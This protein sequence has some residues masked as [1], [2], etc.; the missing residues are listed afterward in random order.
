[1]SLLPPSYMSLLPPP[2]CPFSPLLH[3]PSPPSYMTCP[4]SP[5]LH[6]PSPPSYMSLLPPPTCPFSPLL[7]VPSPPSYMS[8]LFLLHVPPP[9]PTCP[10]PPPP[11]CPSSP[12]YMSLLTLLHVPPPPSYMSLL[13]LLLHTNHWHE[14]LSMPTGMN[15]TIT[16][17]S[18][19]TPD[20]QP[21]PSLSFPSLPPPPPLL[22]YISGLFHLNCLC[23]MTLPVMAVRSRNSTTNN[24]IPNCKHPLHTPPTPS[25][26]K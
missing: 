3:V 14:I 5:L 12:S 24:T 26:I 1:M 23:E 20:I 10:P 16:C 18:C 25:K 21:C 15:L 22:H 11:T 8:L 7:H 6:V 13:P 2:T 4:F 17:R 19:H 9:P